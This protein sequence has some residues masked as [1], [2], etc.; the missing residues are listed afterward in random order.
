[1]H[2]RTQDNWFQPRWLMKPSE[3]VTDL[4]RVIGLVPDH[5][6]SEKAVHEICLK[7]EVSAV[8]R[9][10]PESTDA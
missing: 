4:Q 6:D 10:R 5:G 2:T 1:M 3:F 8:L 9:H 7:L